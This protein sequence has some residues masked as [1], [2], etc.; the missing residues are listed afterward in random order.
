MNWI[1]QQHNP[2][3]A[4]SV[5][6]LLI[7]AGIK[8]L[9][10]RSGDFCFLAPFRQFYSR[11]VNIDIKLK[12]F[13][14][15]LDMRKFSIFSPYEKFHCGELSVGDAHNPDIPIFR[16]QALNSADMD[17]RILNGRTLSQINGKLKHGKSVAQKLLP[18]LGSHLALLL[19]FGR[20]IKEH[21]YPHNT[22]FT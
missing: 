7:A 22:I 12:K 13:Q 19:C 6:H 21:K 16:E 9:R 3:Y 8:N 20:Q 17:I 1:S 15:L 10:S 5:K 18:E 4:L 14:L 2:R 11:E